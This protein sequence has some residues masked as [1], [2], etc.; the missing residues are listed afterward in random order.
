MLNFLREANMLKKVLFGISVL[1]IFAGCF[2]ALQPVEI[3]SIPAFFWKIEQTNINEWNLSFSLSLK[4][5]NGH[6]KPFIANFKYPKTNNW[7]YSNRM[8]LPFPEGSRAFTVY[9]GR[10][11][12]QPN[13]WAKI[14]RLKNK[15]TKNYT[16]NCLVAHITPQ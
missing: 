15:W 7:S 6:Y 14:Y 9:F 3:E 11:F 16:G 1:A 2:Y 10:S 4:A 13:T 8:R 12:P 5:Q